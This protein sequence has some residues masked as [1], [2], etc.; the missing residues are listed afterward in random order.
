M[1]ANLAIAATIITAL[2]TWDLAGHLP[3]PSAC[4]A[5]KAPPS[6]GPN[7]LRRLRDVAWARAL[8]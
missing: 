8:N 1:T 2:V 5:T 4:S 6:S 7:S 3:L